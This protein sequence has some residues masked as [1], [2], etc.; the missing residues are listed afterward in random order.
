MR[1][2]KATVARL[3]PRRRASFPADIRRH[4][5]VNRPAM[6]THYWSE[7]DLPRVIHPAAT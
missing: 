3:A 7:R 1:R 4:V 5:A 6:L 2:T